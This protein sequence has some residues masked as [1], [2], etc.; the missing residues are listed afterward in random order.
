MCASARLQGA[1][2]QSALGWE[3]SHCALGLR[4]AP[5][6]RGG[7]RAGPLVSQDAKPV[8]CSVNSGRQILLP[9]RDP[10]ARPPAGLPQGAA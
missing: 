2:A 3:R 10:R 6:G 7:P 4:R 9:G 5:S 8:R 1:P